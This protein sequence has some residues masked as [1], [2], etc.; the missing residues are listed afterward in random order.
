ME[1]FQNADTQNMVFPSHYYYSVRSIIFKGAGPP[2]SPLGP[3]AT[4]L[5]HPS[6]TLAIGKQHY[7]D[8]AAVW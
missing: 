3:A 2:S 4:Q 1:I 8:V 6:S 7:Q 5:L